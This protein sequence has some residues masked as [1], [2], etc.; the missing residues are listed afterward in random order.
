MTVVSV[1]KR[2]TMMEYKERGGKAPRILNTGEFS[3]SRSGGL[4]S[5]KRDSGIN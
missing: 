2:H 1:A 3:G 5:M 4:T